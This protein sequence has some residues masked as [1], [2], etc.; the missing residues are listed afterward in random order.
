MV[1]LLVVVT[2]SSYS[3]DGS[4]HHNIYHI[5]TEHVLYIGYLKLRH[6]TSST[7]RIK[8]DIG[9]SESTVKKERV[10]S[11]SHG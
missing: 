5:Y 3:I 7:T 1:C 6:G 11:K 4:S 10:D 8:G 2:S 9:T